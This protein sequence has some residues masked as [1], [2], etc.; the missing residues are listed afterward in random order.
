ML[1]LKEQFRILEI[2]NNEISN[3]CRRL[4]IDSSYFTFSKEEFLKWCESVDLNHFC[5]TYVGKGDGLYFVNHRDK[6]WMLYWQEREIA[7]LVKRFTNQTEGKIYTI[8]TRLH[9]II[10]HPALVSILALK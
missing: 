4:D 10:D 6:N 1:S 5:F 3:E 9:D 7:S 8:A 2:G